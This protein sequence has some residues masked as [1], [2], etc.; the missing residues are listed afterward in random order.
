MSRFVLTNIQYKCLCYPSS[1]YLCTAKSSISFWLLMSYS[2]LFIL[3]KTDFSR[4]CLQCPSPDCSIRLSMAGLLSTSVFS[5]RSS[6]M[7]ARGCPFRPAIFLLNPLLCHIY[8]MYVRRGT[9]RMEVKD[10]VGNT[11][12]LFT[13]KRKNKKIR[14]WIKAVSGRRSHESEHTRS[15][16]IW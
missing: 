9:N 14:N 3:T 12:H 15:G 7:Y 13:K 5:P 2:C 11:L 4:D 16:R 6:Y 1:Y 8:M 10:N